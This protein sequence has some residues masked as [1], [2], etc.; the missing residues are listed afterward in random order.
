[1]KVILFLRSEILLLITNRK[2]L[3]NLNRIKIL[4]MRENHI[5]FLLIAILLF[6]LIIADSHQRLN[7]VNSTDLENISYILEINGGFSPFI[8]MIPLLDG[9]STNFSSKC[10]LE[11]LIVN[12]SG[13]FGSLA[14]QEEFIKSIDT[15]YRTKT[16]NLTNMLLW[17]Y[18][19]IESWENYTI[20]YHNL[21]TKNRYSILKYDRFSGVLWEVRYYLNNITEILFV[22]TNKGVTTRIEW[23][24][25]SLIPEDF[26][27][28]NDLYLNGTV[29][30]DLIEEPVDQTTYR[31]PTP[32]PTISLIFLVVVPFIYYFSKIKNILN[33]GRK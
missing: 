24:N 8:F 23:H 25:S 16:Q 9:Y 29:Y 11:S 13:Y 19:T 28:G 7:N 17:V 20:Q 14:F 27:I 22:D 5:K 6:Q 31:A 10:W 12:S 4:S 26:N 33:W 18:R 32:F 3:K 21:S 2:D 1:M 15:I 30:I